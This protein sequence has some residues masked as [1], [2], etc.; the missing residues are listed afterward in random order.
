[1][2]ACHRRFYHTYCGTAWVIKQRKIYCRTCMA[3]YHLHVQNEKLLSSAAYG[4]IVK[5]FLLFA[6]FLIIVLGFNIFDKYLKN[7]KAD[8]S[9]AQ[10]FTQLDLTTIEMCMTL[11]LIFAWCFCLLLTGQFERT[12]R[13]LSVEVLDFNNDDI[14]ISRQ[15]A[16]QNLNTIIEATS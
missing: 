7:R 9:F 4:V 5:Y 2:C 1:M 16:K 8:L 12:K 6:V 10:L 15:Q 13:I 3:Y 11:V 14:L